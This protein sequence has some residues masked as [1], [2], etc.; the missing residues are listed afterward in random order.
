MATPTKTKNPQD[1]ALLA[2]NLKRKDPEHVAG[3]LKADLVKSLTC[4]KENNI[5]ISAYADLLRLILLG[6]KD[7]RYLTE[8]LALVKH[9]N[10]CLCSIT[11]SQLNIYKFVLLFST[12]IF[13]RHT[14]SRHTF[15]RHT[16]STYRF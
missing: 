1:L 12:Y 7:V 14:I 9:R 11:D 15:S 16:F 13:S 5:D 4:F 8:S 10:H 6:R 2:R 3:T